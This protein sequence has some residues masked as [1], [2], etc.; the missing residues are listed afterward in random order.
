[1]RRVWILLALAFAADA[2]AQTE[3]YQ[4]RI[5]NET[6]KGRAF[7]SVAYFDALLGTWVTRGWYPQ[8]DGRCRDVLANL[9]AP[10]YVYAESKDG[11]KTYGDPEGGRAFCVDESKGFVL[12]QR[13]CD[14]AGKTR[15]FEKLRLPQGGGAVTWRVRN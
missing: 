3:R 5:C 2:A 13:R 1:M 8:D 7:A 12:D 9:P 14:E 6:G 10:V 15:R 4:L 11:S